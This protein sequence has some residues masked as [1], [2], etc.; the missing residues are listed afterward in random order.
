MLYY[1]KL[2][3]AHKT[4]Q[5]DQLRVHRRHDYDWFSKLQ[6]DL[7][8]KLSESTIRV[9][10]F[11]VYQLSQALF[12]EG[13]DMVTKETVSA[14]LRSKT[15][16]RSYVQLER[17]VYRTVNL[18]FFELTGEIPVPLNNSSYHK[19][20]VPCLD[21]GT[22][23]RERVFT[24]DEIKRMLSIPGYDVHTELMLRI[25]FTTGL[26]IGALAAMKWAQVLDTSPGTIK[27]IV[28][29]P[30]KGGTERGIFLTDEIRDIL[31]NMSRNTSPDPDSR[32]FPWRG[33]LF[34]R[35]CSRE[36]CRRHPGNAIEV[37]HG[38]QT[39]RHHRDALPP[40]QRAPFR[41]AHPF[42]PGKFHRDDFQVLGAPQR[43]H[44][45]RMLSAIDVRGNSG[46][47]EHPLDQRC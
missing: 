14:V 1:N 40:T 9:V 7:I 43:E 34:S 45:Q 18:V 17:R 11:N 46:T 6:K 12:K 31:G 25:L 41:R 42:Q 37:L 28:I 35:H 27:H 5:W 15:T 24:P 8:G 13:R 16:Y 2:E 22:R 30:E 4:D 20:R 26:R 19:Q 44:H 32:V 29:V 38:L 39:R 23:E 33:R 10:L 47:D 36:N 21:N 3:R